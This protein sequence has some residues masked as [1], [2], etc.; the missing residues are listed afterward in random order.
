MFDPSKSTAANVDRANDRAEARCSAPCDWLI[1]CCLPW[2][3]TGFFICLSHIYFQHKYNSTQLVVSH[4]PR[5]A[6]HLMKK[7]LYPDQTIGENGVPY[8]KCQVRS[9][10]MSGWTQTT[11]A[12]WTWL[13]IKKLNA[14]SSTS[15]VTTK[16]GWR[17][18]E[19]T[20]LEKWYWIQ[21][22]FGTLIQKKNC[23]LRC[24]CLRPH[25]KVGI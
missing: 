23:N 15:L 13:N 19:V 20:G 22:L 24:Y 25:V 4:G 16:D 1:M 2:L 10:S 17:S 21:G 11:M 8:K 14:A 9:P 18:K 5:C 6:L 3:Y 7:M 12:W